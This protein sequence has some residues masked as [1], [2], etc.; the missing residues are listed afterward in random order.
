MRC[1]IMLSAGLAMS[2]LTCGAQ[3]GIAD[4]AGVA[5]SDSIDLTRPTLFV[6]GY[7]HL[8]TQWRWT[9]IDTIRDFIPATMERNYDLFEKY[10]DY[11]FNFGGSRRYE[12]MEE[13][14]PD[15]FARLHDYIKTGRWFPC[16]SSVDENDANVPSAESQI[17]H[18][19]YGNR[20][21]RR[22]FG[23]ASDEFMLPDCFGFP[24]G[25][26]SVLAHCGIKGFSTQKLTW[27]AVVP[28]PFKVGVW[29]GPDGRSVIAALD[30]GSYAGDVRE[31]LSKSDSWEQRIDN[32]GKKSGVFVDYH[33]YGTGDTGGA[34]KEDSVAMIETGVKNGRKPDAPIHV[35]SSTSDAMIHAITDDQRAHLP[36]YKGEL[37]LT[38]HSAGSVSSQAYMKRWNRK[39][40]LL[41]DSAERA[42]TAAW[43]LGSGGYPADRLEKAWGLVLGSQM[44]DI[45]PGTSVPLAYDLSWNDEVIAA[46]QFGAVLTDAARA[47]ISGMD[48]LAD[49]TSIVVFNP[50]AWDRSDVVEADVPFTGPTPIGVT[51]T[52]PDGRP[53]PAQILHVA[54]GV[55]H[56]AFV[57]DAP[58]VG[59]ASYSV[60]LGQATKA[61]QASALTIAPDGKR[62]ENGRYVVELNDRGDVSSIYDKRAKQELLRAPARIG[63]HYEN[64][65]QWP[66]WNQD[67]DDRIKPAT[68]YVGES[69]PVTFT[70]VENGPARVAV[71]VTR[72][73]EGSVFTQR[74]RLGAGSDRVEF[75]TDIDWSTRERSVRAAFPLTASN[76]EATYDIQVGTLDRPNMHEKQYEYGFQ[77][78][79][80]LTDA[81]GDFG[82]TVMCDSKYGSD[83]PDDNTVRLTMVYTPGV[84]GGYPDQ[85]SQDIGRHHILYA[86]QGHTGDW[87]A[88]RSYEQAARLNQPLVPF[89]AP[90]HAGALGKRFSMV[91]VSDPRVSVQ[92]L[93]KAEDS[94]EVIVR[95]R[96]QSGEDIR[97]V[98]VSVGDRVLAAREVDGQERPIG[99]AKV[100]DGSLVTDI[101]GYGLRAFALRIAEPSASERIAA[102][103]STPVD[104]MFD[105]DAI[106]TN[107]NPADGAMT[108]AHEAYPAEQMPGSLTVDGVEFELGSGAK[109]SKLN[110]ITARGQRIK[111][112]TGS[113]NRVEL[114][115]ASSD[116][117]VDATFSVSG[118]KARATVQDW[119][120]YVGQWDHREWPGEVF[121]PR[122]PWGSTDIIGLT[123]GFAK[124]AEI[125]WYVSHHHRAD[126]GEHGSD[127][128]YR[129]C[130][131]F[132]I[133]LDAPKGADTLILPN[134]PRV[135]IF[136]VSTVSKAD[137]STVP[138]APLFDTLKDHV[139]GPPSIAA[140]DG[141]TDDAG[142]FTDSV[143]VAVKHGLYWQ[144]GSYHYTIDGSTPT[145]ASPV[146][147]GP[148]TLGKSATVRVVAQ[149][150]DGSL[151]PV[152]SETVKVNDRTPPALA[153]ASGMYETP[154][155]TVR[156]SEPVASVRADQF[157]LDPPIAI[158]G[159]GVSDDGR[160]VA[161]H[162]ASPPQVGQEYTLIAG[163][164]KD[165]SPS[166]NTLT[167]ASATF[168]V[169][170]PVFTLDEI[171]HDL[172]GKSFS[173]IKDLPVSGDDPWTMNVWVKMDKQ[174]TNH[175]L[176]V[177]FGKASGMRP[178]QARYLCKFAN[179]VH[180]W[181]HNQDAPGTVQYDLGRWQMITTTFDGSVARVYKDGELIGERAVRLADDDNVV[182]I[183]P[184]D[185]WDRRYHFGGDLAGLTIWNSALPAP[186]IKTL[187][188]SSPN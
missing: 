10:P 129:Y 36:R 110:A 151:G 16:G 33:Y 60:E 185:P 51:V 101:H 147:E 181:S 105:T 127:A 57:A 67:W 86:V 28:I 154:E 53:A 184:V 77:Q 32:N 161:V 64:P 68:S 138:A 37:E 171:G 121:D 139:Q 128:L 2:I 125:G 182:N 4:E 22:E 81:S 149:H 72:E 134:D 97:G 52:G 65:S 84:R 11:V 173:D 155:V 165:A 159:V 42:S 148:I 92:A 45:L 27:N 40:E 18:A 169:P 87:R 6:V 54:D 93:K 26:P 15:D 132:K 107:A 136:A 131:L 7:A 30:P 119:G 103:R 124:P 102:T 116:G 183:A 79:F 3:A 142:V 177:G 130:Y 106:S 61:A 137:P 69:G 150:A 80:D 25:L 49:G 39:N 44:H 41:A 23:V 78:W 35:V 74:I 158:R 164:I 31:D 162:L 9:Y 143:E 163:N 167:Q 115:A 157:R 133:G 17:R 111:L 70:V 156:F 117:D 109:D 83:K 153:G 175:T 120:D 176:L 144:Q 123:P 98:R 141:P 145:A 21:F 172:Y 62:L 82:T 174:P 48:T 96:E 56:V 122:Y 20:Y 99:D 85:S 114:L 170:G 50:L 91:Q 75:D 180:F 118:A 5:Q 12:M 90:G 55:A 100:T 178:G 166:G 89:R 34:P 58:S 108:I 88:E 59:F 19:L 188:A 112:P 104:L 94:D 179:G 13:Y 66:A 160:S 63:L 113:F 73:A 24:A 135:K 8:D 146:Y 43:W 152:A 168:S 14:Y 71:E 38:Q 126:G 1:A 47:V 187:V 46:N 29:E 95:L 186:A 140:G 76:P